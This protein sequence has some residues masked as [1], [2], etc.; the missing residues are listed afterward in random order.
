MQMIDGG[1][2]SVILTK[3]VSNPYFQ[4][5]FKPGIM[6]HPSNLSTQEEEVGGL[7]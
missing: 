4:N 2:N 3:G 7:L 6:V 5:Y 1:V